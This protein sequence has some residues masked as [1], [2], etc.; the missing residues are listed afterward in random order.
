MLI[1][2]IFLLFLGDGD[3]GELYFARVAIV[4]RRRGFARDVI[5]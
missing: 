1:C 5:F 3:V 2:V 4:F